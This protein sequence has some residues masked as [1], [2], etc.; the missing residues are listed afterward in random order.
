VLIP[1]PETEHVI[2][3]A[4]KEPATRILD[5]GCGSGAI[6]ITLRLESGAEVWASDISFPALRIAAGNAQRLGARVNFVNG[7]LDSAFA[8]RAFD[9]IVSNPPYV[10]AAELE[11]LSREIRDHEPHVALTSGP[12]GFEIYERLI[13][14]ARRTLRPGGRLILEL[15]Y[16]SSERVVQLLSGGFG[17]IH[18][19]ADLAGI[20]R[21]V[22]CRLLT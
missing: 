14:G 19:T 7:D 11:G 8:D 21:V 10:P 5:I 22:S 4:L 18:L 9:L 16:N 12:T 15:G 2:E 20:P 13:T 3:V 17:D 6:A 1:R